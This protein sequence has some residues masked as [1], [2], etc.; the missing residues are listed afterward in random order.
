MITKEIDK[1]FSD[2]V[3]AK[4]FLP[5]KDGV[6]AFAHLLG[7]ITMKGQPKLYGHKFVKKKYETN[8]KK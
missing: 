1:L 4:L 3:R 8:N 7:Q 5:N 6:K 2:L